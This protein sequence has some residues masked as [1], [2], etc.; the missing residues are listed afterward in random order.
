MWAPSGRPEPSGPGTSP[1]QEPARV[2]RSRVGRARSGGR[3]L[4]WAAE[5][6]EPKPEPKRE[7]EPEPDPGRLV[8]G[9][10]QGGAGGAGGSSPVLTSAGTVHPGAG[11]LRAGGSWRDGG[12]GRRPHIPPVAGGCRA[13]VRR[14]EEGRGPGGGGPWQPGQPGRMT[15]EGNALSEAESGP[16]GR[17][18]RGPALAA[19]GHTTPADAAPRG[20]GHAAAGQAAPDPERGTRPG[21]LEVAALRA[22][23][24][25]AAHRPAHNSRKPGYLSACCH[26]Y[27]TWTHIHVYTGLESR[28]HTSGKDPRAHKYR[29][30]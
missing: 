20:G 9:R 23:A 26:A 28:R 5:Q 15:M 4:D 13:T 30:V 2:P 14:R 3:T 10:A 29:Q 6:L 25:A 11:A 21:P 22:A 18:G 1:G 24:G 27:T 19:L 16:R 17:G 12:L 7:P 8:L